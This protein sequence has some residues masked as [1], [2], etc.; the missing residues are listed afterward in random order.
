[1]DPKKIALGTLVFFV[2]SF[3]IQGLLGFV[4]GGEYFMSIPIMRQPP[5]AYLAMSATILTGIAIAVL[6]PITN[7][8]G[9]PVVRGLKFGLLTGLLMIPF[10]ALD[11][12]GRFA[13]PSV[14]TWILLQGI[15]GLVHSSVAGVL[16]GLVYGKEA[17]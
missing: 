1:M 13:I 12:P 5:L 11:L 3:V 17:K 7:L 16:I 4:I 10:V 15:L 2:S 14:G 9:T 8:S 6:Y